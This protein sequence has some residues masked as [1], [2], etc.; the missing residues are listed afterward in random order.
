[1]AG[2]S[3][4]VRRLGL[5]IS[6]VV[7]VLVVGGTA[8]GAVPAGADRITELPTLG[9]VAQPQF[10]GYASTQAADCAD[11]ACT[12]RPGLFY[13]LVGHGADYR[14][15][16]TVLWSNGGPGA[17]SFY[18]LLSENGPYVVG[19]HG[20]V[21]YPH[22]WTSTANYII[23]DH[24]L[25]VGMSFPFHG[26][27]ARNPVEGI[28]QLANAVDHVVQREGLG[29][30][31]LFLTGESYGGTYMPLLAQRLLADHPNVHVGGVVIVD[32]WV[33]P[34]TQVGTSTEY[35]L[36]HGLIDA[37][38]KLTLDRVYKRCR[39]L[40]RKPSTALKAAEVCQSI[41]DK[42]AAMSGRYLA[43]IAQEGDIDYAPIQAFLN[44]P[45]VR[46]AIHARPEGT[47]ALGSDPVYQAYAHDVMHN[48]A[49]VVA[50]LLDRGVRVLVLTGLNDGKDTN[51]LGVRKWISKLQW[52]RKARYTRAVTLQ[53]KVG[54]A[55]RGYQ[56][57]GGGLTNLE[58][59]DAG[60]L[61]PR[62]Q[63]LIADFMQQFM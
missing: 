6:F 28:R 8:G 30:S 10:A 31:P 14:E 54:G 42:I 37:K 7:V 35:A 1:M 5:I 49:D 45:D 4:V 53:W 19:A 2:R 24:P 15:Q 40:L 44:R 11:L 12:D 13:W 55:V 59:L 61:A 26:Q 33:D 34:E 57:S 52:P 39:A 18:G 9:P 36:T 16:P 58:V 3:C 25:G 20:L 50:K 41:Q 62:D 29:Q 38:Q 56:R 21:P 22:S 17:S 47:F 43:N 23:F 32:G 48:Y 60:H 63:P 51:F 27:I 46:A